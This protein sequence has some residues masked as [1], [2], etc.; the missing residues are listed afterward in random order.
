MITRR[1][2]VQLGFATAAI[3][4]ATVLSDSLL[5]PSIKSMGA[6]LPESRL[7]P[8][9]SAQFLNG[10][11]GGGATVQTEWVKSNAEVI[12]ASE[13]LLAQGVRV[14]IAMIATPLVTLLQPIYAKHQALLV[15]VNAGEN[16]PVIESPN[17]VYSTLHYAEAAF[18]A[19]RYGAQRFGPRGLQ[20]S[21]WYESGFDTFYAFE[22]GLTQAGGELIQSVITHTADGANLGSAIDAIRVAQPDFVY[23]AYYG[24]NGQ[25]FMQAYRGA[26]LFGQIPLL[27]SAF[28]SD[29]SPLFAGMQTIQAT[30]TSQAFTLLGQRTIEQL[31]AGQ[32]KPISSL[33]VRTI[34]AGDQHLLSLPHG[35][36]RAPEIKSGWN[37]SYLAV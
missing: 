1:Q 20:V 36:I 34:G 24:D 37:R 7:N 10:L 13:R 5:T 3:T 26:G 14:V 27:G 22:Q 17:V 15:V 6:I 16:L 2:F 4:P 32:F 30:N 11:I 25:E 31:R 29:D 8:L 18:M 19:G 23:A 9:L 35:L 33:T 12:T 21:S 28:M